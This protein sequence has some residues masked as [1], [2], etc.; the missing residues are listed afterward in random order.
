MI[1]AI[2]RRSWAWS[3]RMPGAVCRKIRFEA[4]GAAAHAEPCRDGTRL[5]LD[6]RGQPD[7][8]SNVAQLGGCQRR[9]TAWIDGA[10]AQFNQPGQHTINL[11]STVTVGGLS[12]AG[13][14]CTVS[15]G[16]ILL[17]PATAGIG[18]Q[19]QSTAQINTTIRST[20]GGTPALAGVGTDQVG[21]LDKTGGG[22]LVV[23][24]IDAS[25]G[26]ITVN[27][28]VLRVA[29]NLA[30]QNHTI[31]VNANNG[32]TFAAGVTNPSIGGLAGSG[33]IVLQDAATPAT[34][35]VTLTVGQNG[36]ST[37][38]SG[39]LSGSGG[40]IKT[41]PERSPSP[42]RTPATRTV[43]PR[44]STAAPSSPT[45]RWPTVR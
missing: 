39:S 33:N 40:L 9:P 14:S 26:D 13:G 45:I 41:A 38:F 16:T 42:T 1:A 11:V 25:I 36:D 28:G 5:G 17:G 21:G 12:F 27:A 6:R 15:G 2:A 32:L 4:A 10:V 43:A 24:G 19:G 8:E 3:R 37:T 20:G 30:A 18:V 31:V 7:L 35:P 22:T 23:S 34:R 44:S 29:S